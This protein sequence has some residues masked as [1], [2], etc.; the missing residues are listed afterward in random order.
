MR[1][2]SPVRTRPSRRTRAYT[3]LQPGWR[4]CEMRPK[5]R[6]SN[7]GAMLKQGLVYLVICRST[8][9]PR[10]R[11][12][13]GT[14]VD[15]SSPSVVTFS[16]SAPGVTRWP[17]ATSPWMAASA[18]RHTA[19]SSPPWCSRLRWASPSRPSCVTRA[20]A[21]GRLGRPP[22]DTLSCTIVPLSAPPSLTHDLLATASGRHPIVREA[23]SGAPA[24]DH[25]P[26]DGLQHELVPLVQHSMRVGHDAA[27]GLLRLP[28]VADGDLDADGV[29]F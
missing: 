13:P 7:S 19:R 4:F 5:F 26:D 23:A 24:P 6:P 18:N 22:G 27:V 21:T 17:S 3:R 2:G 10:S 15:Q 14:T 1:T 25:P 9:S 28:L 12:A 20:S 8:C 16:P 29:A 11:W